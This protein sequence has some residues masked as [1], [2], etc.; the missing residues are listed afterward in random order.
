VPRTP[1]RDRARA[2]W[3][4]AGCASQVIPDDRKIRLTNPSARLM[5]RGVATQLICALFFGANTLSEPG[6]FSLAAGWVVMQKYS[7]SIGPGR[8]T[9][10]VG[11]VEPGAARIA[12]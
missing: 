8:S 3:S 4:T 9:Q 2:L 5:C 7:F 11:L 1:I 10:A 6:R 12:E